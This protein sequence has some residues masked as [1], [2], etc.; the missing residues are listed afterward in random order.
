MRL[1]RP[2]GTPV[3][4]AAV[5]LA[6]VA[7]PAFLGAKHQESEQELLDRIEHESNM[8]KKA[9]LQAE[10]ATLKLDEAATAFDQDQYESGKKL[11]DQYSGWIHKAWNVL[12]ESG[13]DATR[14]AQGFK[15]LDISLRE[16]A[17]ALADLA[18]R[19][20]FADRGP[21]EATAK[22]ADDVH[23]QVIAALFPGGVQ[24]DGDP[25]AKAQAQDAPRPPADK[26]APVSKLRAGGP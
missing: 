24:E 14:K 18:E 3:L 15:D 26:P 13:R 1:A 10:L 19:T 11:L 25:T 16:N 2:S 9:R 20:P 6:I 7:A 8:A 21:I 22:T 12:E 4:I 5:A 23:S 17:R